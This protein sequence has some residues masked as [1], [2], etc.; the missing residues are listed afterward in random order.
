VP[1]RVSIF[2]AFP[3]ASVCVFV[4]AG[5]SVGVWVCGLCPRS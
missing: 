5:V 2:P 4:G 1:Q 3:R